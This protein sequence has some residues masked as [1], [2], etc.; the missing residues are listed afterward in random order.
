MVTLLD[1]LRLLQHHSSVQHQLTFE[2]PSLAWAEMYILVAKLVQRFD[3]Q[4]QGAGPKDVECV[5]D[6]FII[7]TADPSGIKAVITRYEN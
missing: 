7:G 6:Q 3:I 2:L 4:L 5:S 1:N